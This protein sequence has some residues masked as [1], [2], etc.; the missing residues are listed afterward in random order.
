MEE[1]ELSKPSPRQGD[2]EKRNEGRERVPA[3]M[4]FKSTK[5][6]WATFAL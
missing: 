6:L 5:A 2:G 3:I 1:I 4:A